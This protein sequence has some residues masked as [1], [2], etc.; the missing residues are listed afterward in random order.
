MVAVP[1]VI[2]VAFCGAGAE[3][4]QDAAAQTHIDDLHSLADSQD[5]HSGADGQVEGL[6]LQDIQLSV[7]IAGAMVLLPEEGGGDIPSSRKQQG[8]AAADLFRLQGDKGCESKGTDIF[9]VIEG[10]G[11]SADNSNFHRISFQSS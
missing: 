8:A 7:D 6:Q 2:P 4:L 10:I 3:I 5:W 11:S 9:D 1:V